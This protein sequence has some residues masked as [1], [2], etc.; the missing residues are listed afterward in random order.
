MNKA[1]HFPL[2]INAP[3]EVPL[4]ISQHNNL[5][6]MG[7]ASFMIHWPIVIADH[8]DYLKLYC[9]EWRGNYF[10]EMPRFAEV[11]PG[12][13]YQEAEM[14]YFKIPKETKLYTSLQKYFKHLFL[15][16]DE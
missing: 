11:I 8:G 1:L 3:K 12:R 10:H 15:K 5:S 9:E 14:A 7:L 16:K 13:I 6:F 4:T 2:L